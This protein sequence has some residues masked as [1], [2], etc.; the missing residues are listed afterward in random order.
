MAGAASLWLMFGLLL[1]KAPNYTRLSIILPFVAYLALTGFVGI[2]A[3]GKWLLSKNKFIA[4]PH[5]EKLLLGSMV[6]G[7]K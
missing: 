4:V 7:P 1:I 3:D 2:A 6:L 5:L